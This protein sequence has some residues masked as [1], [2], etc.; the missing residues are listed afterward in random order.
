MKISDALILAIDTET[1]GVDCESDRIVELGGAYVRGGYRWGPSLSSFVN[2]ER[3]IPPEA[4]RIHRITDEMV[5][6]APLWPV[7]CQWLR[8]HIEAQP[9]VLAGYNILAFDLPLIHAENRRAGIDWRLPVPL[10]PYLFARWY[11]P[12]RS[13]KLTSIAEFYGIKLPESEAHRGDADS[14]ATAL[15]LIAMVWAGYIPDD[16]EAA[17]KKQGE[18]EAAL[19]DERK[20]FGRWL[21]ID[22]EDRETLRVA[23][24]NNRGRAVRELDDSVLKKMMEYKE[25]TEEGRESIRRLVERQSALF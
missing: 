5:I 3:M 4:S 25:M 16:L 24:Q 18:I 13:S 17:L 14:I 22:R 12:E 1:T 8:A 15:L 2:P 21:Y 7:I 6:D 10:D 20:R 11:H 19:I 9:L 23:I